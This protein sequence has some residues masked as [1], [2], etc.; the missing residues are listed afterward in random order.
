MAAQVLGNFQL[1]F[2][3]PYILYKANLVRIDKVVLFM[4][5][6]LISGIFFFLFEVNSNL[7]T[8]FL[9]ISSNEYW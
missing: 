8:P 5:T 9:F 4:F 3:F 2:F 7:Q 1:S 6:V